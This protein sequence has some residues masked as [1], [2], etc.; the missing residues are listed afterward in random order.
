[1]S[2]LK[3]KRHQ[4]TCAERVYSSLHRAAREYMLNHKQYCEQDLED[5]DFYLAEVKETRE[6]LDLEAER[7]DRGDVNRYYE[8]PSTSSKTGNA[9]QLEWFQPE[10]ELRIDGE[11]M[12]WWE[13]GNPR[14]MEMQAFSA[15]IAASETHPESKVQLLARC[16]S[17]DF[18][19]TIEEANS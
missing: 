8:I 4:R 13:G 7:E 17:G 11:P 15:A 19:L 3:L 18:L 6:F 16:Y 9:V 10:T 12:Q 1:M 2:L 14:S 5:E